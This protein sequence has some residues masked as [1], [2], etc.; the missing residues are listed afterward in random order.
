MEMHPWKHAE[1]LAILEMLILFHIDKK[2][3]IYHLLVSGKQW[4]S[5]IPDAS[6]QQA[7]LFDFKLNCHYLYKLTN[8]LT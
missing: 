7:K 3:A 4:K 2:V 1:V 8:Q 6:H 5:D